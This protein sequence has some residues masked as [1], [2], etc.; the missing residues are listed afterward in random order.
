MTTAQ[1]AREGYRSVDAV[2][3][4]LDEGRHLALVHI[5]HESFDHYQ[6][7]FARHAFA[8][9]FARHLPPVYREHQPSQHIGETIRA[10]S[11]P[12]HNELVAQFHHSTMAER[13]YNDIKNGTLRGWSF[14]YRN[15]Q[16]IPHPVHP[17][18]IRYV[19]ADFEELSA[20]SRPAIPGTLTAGLRSQVALAL[21]RLALIEKAQPSAHTVKR[22]A[23]EL[24]S[25]LEEDLAWQEEVARCVAAQD[26]RLLRRDIGRARFESRL[27]RATANLARHRRFYH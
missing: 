20:V 14:W 5:P 13:A 16:S 17:G 7:D 9:S 12:A 11:L 10:Q 8:E 24:R 1:P 18:G 6:T 27:A 19:K 25:L 21:G 26:A 3:H 4:D 22:S 23:V 2:V 15:A